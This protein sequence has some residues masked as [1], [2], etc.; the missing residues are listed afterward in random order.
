MRRSILEKMY[1]KKQISI[2]EPTKSGKIIAIDFTRKKEKSFL[3][4]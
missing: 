4:G 1:F 3:M 2:L